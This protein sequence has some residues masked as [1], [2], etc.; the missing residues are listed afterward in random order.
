MQKAPETR[1]PHTSRR[2]TGTASAGDSTR[3]R[4]MTA[5]IEKPKPQWPRMI[6]A[7]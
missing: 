4:L 7:N 6:P 2:I 3:D 1:H 5:V